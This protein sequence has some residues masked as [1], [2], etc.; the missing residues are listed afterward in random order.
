MTTGLRDDIL[1][2]DRQVYLDI[3][4]KVVPKWRRSEQVLESYG[5]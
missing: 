3:S 2:A 5:Y 1:P 4:I